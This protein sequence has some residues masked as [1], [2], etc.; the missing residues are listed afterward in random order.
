VLGAFGAIA[1]AL[2]TLTDSSLLDDF[3]Y[4]KAGQYFAQTHV[5]R[6]PTDSAVN[7]V[8]EALWGGIFSGVFGFSHR[9]LRVPYAGPLHTGNASWW[10][11]IAPHIDS[12]YIVGSR[13]GDGYRVVNRTPIDLW[14]GSERFVLVLKK[15]SSAPAPC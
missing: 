6:I 5:I 7:A 15:N 8:F 1:V 14:L 13:P 3:V 4:A 9:V 2:P 12:T 10:L 11:P